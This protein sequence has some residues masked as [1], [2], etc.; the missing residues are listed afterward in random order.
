MSVST[1]VSSLWA[2]TASL[3]LHADTHCSLESTPTST[4]QCNTRG[5]HWGG[6]ARIDSLD[7]NRQDRLN[8]TRVRTC[9]A[10]CP[11]ISRERWRCASGA[12]LNASGPPYIQPSGK[13]EVASAKTWDHRRVQPIGAHTQRLKLLQAHHRTQFH[14]WRIYGAVSH[15][16]SAPA[17]C[18]VGRPG[19]ASTP[20]NMTLANVFRG[21]HRGPVRA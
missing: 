1:P 15:E 5:T 10:H 4:L 3:H 20:Q 7:Q 14:S 17:Q 13:T 21:P 2:C 8:S 11:A 12:G 16:R 6:Q 9:Q 19:D 18:F